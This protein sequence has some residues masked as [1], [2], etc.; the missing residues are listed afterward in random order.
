MRSLAPFASSLPT[1]NACF[2][3]VTLG[4]G[5]ERSAYA[6]RALQP[7]MLEF[8]TNAQVKAQDLGFWVAWT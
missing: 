2:L 8:T 7:G 4:V 5:V 6:G 3:G 1:F